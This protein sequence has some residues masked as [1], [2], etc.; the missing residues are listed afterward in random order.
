[1]IQDIAWVVVAG[2]FLYVL[3]LLYQV[4]RVDR[5][6]RAH[7]PAAPPAPA[8]A[9]EEGGE[10]FQVEL[11]VHQ[12]RRELAQL[13]VEQEAQRR[14]ISDLDE[15]FSALKSQFDSVGTAPEY[16]EALVFARRG[17]NVD[18]IAERCGISV[19]EAELVRALAQRGSEADEPP[20]A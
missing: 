15:R 6:V 11:E 10:R 4:S 19:S 18:A 8:A 3:Y 2:L 14:L 16:S 13:Q 12:L 5:A 7:Q 1:M 17:L 20:R 9:S